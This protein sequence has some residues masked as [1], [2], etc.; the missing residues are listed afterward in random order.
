[1]MDLN[2][3]DERGG[4]LITRWM[5]RNIDQG[6]GLVAH[7]FVLENEVLSSQLTLP[8]DIVPQT[9]GRVIATASG[10]DWAL[11]SDI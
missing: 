5:H 10:N 9:N 11:Y 3:I 1:M 7:G 8:R 2:L 6:L 4:K